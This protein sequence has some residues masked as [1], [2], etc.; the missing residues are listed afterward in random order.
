MRASAGWFYFCR[1]EFY[2]W[3]S[4]MLDAGAPCAAALIAS[5]EA[6][7]NVFLRAA[8]RIIFSGIVSILEL[9]IRFYVCTS[10]MPNIS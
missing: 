7:V 6:S 1:D 3:Q 9:V 4:A 2:T 5:N 8:A 10:S